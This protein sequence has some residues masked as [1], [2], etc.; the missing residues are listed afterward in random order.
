MAGGARTVGSR[1]WSHRD[2]SVFDAEL[3]GRRLD[4]RLTARLLARLLPH[5]A[6]MLGSGLLVLA[7]SVFAV[8]MPV[9]MSRVII[10][11]VLF[12]T[13]ASAAPTL[14][15]DA[16]ARA[17]E[18]ALGL[19]PLLAAC[20]LY[21]ALVL[22]WT[23]CGHGHRVL[24]AR[25]VQRTLRDLR[26]HLFAH[27]Q[28]LAPSFYDRVAVGRVM[29]RVTND[30]EV[31]FELFWGL[32][33]LVGEVVPF[34][35]ALA[36]MTA[37]DAELA[38]WLL[39]S[40][41]TVGLATWAFGR[42]TRVVYRRVRESISRLNQNLQE[43]LSGV[44]VVQLHRREERNL[45]RYREINRE[46]RAL[47]RRAI[48][49]EVAYGS[50]V[51]SL[52]SAALAAILWFGGRQ[53]LGDWVSLGTLILFARYADLLF[54]PIVAMG[55]QYN[56]LYRAMAS[57]ERIFQLLDWR[58]S[59]REPEAPRALPARLAGRIEIEKLH[60]AYPGGP[61][62]LRGIDLAIAPGEKVA[63]VGATGSG[64]TTLVRLLSR[65]YDFDTGSIR[66][67]GI[68]VRDVPSRELRRRLG[69][70]LQ[71]FHVFTGSVRENLRLG[72]DSIDDARL[73]AA[74]RLVHADAFIRALPRGYDTE[75]AERGANLSHGQ[76]QLLGFA[77]VLA[78]DPEILILDEATASVDPETEQRI[79]DALARITAGRTSILIAH[80]LLTARDADR[81]VVLARG[82]IHAVGSHAEL[83]ARDPLYRTLYAL[84][85]PEEAA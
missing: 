67:D 29:T 14:G 61:P 77:R 1:P 25:A 18:R 54:R 34:A 63:I 84:Q 65:C 17:I 72:D 83:L 33:L 75:L 5:R 82:R 71:D 28:Q 66:I 20:A 24:L 19:S 23:V 7:S 69:S 38:G 12:P 4:L 58:E 22:G 2:H 9:V 51:D 46:N 70:V 36:L 47:E 26:N 74:A 62:V 45:A 80:R 49:L 85:F 21:A 64:K 39:L 56:V 8:L 81:I 52:T 30:V 13:T 37:A 60:F 79:Q 40:I 53:V 6:W 50:F 43:N 31:L 42:A 11:G 27:L 57:S 15:T 55:E 48:D 32:G 73:E 41:P 44:Q 16:A 68:D 76:R 35:L 59:V 3:S 10:D 78:Q